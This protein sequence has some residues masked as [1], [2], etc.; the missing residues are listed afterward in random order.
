VNAA[1][2]IDRLRSDFG[3]LIQRNESRRSVEDFRRYRDDPVGFLR[4][5][6]KSDPWEAQC[7]I[8][9]DVRDHPRV[10]VRSCN[11]LGKDW[12]AARLALWGAYA[13]GSMVIVT[14]P[15]SRQVQQIVFGEIR[16]A[17]H[18][19]LELPG[20]LYELELRID[21]TGHTGIM[22]M[23]STDASRLTGYHAPNMLVIMTEAQA[24]EPFGWEAMLACATSEDSR[25]LAVGNPLN[26]SGQFYRVCKS[27]NWKQ[28]RLSAFDHPNLKESREVIP[29]AVTQQWVETIQA[30]YGEGSGVYR[31]RVL[32]DFPEDD[33]NTL[34][35]RSWLEA[36]NE[37]WT[38]GALTLDAVRHPVVLALDPA[39]LGPDS[40]VLAVRRGPVLEELV[41]WS[42]K[43]T[44]QTVGQVQIEM[45]RRRLTFSTETIVDE[46]G[47]GSGV[48]DRLRE[49]RV[50]VTHFNGGARASKPDKFINRRAESFWILRRKLE[51]GTIALPPDEK[52]T[53]E[54]CSMMW[55]TSSTGKIKIE[56]KDLLRERLGRS[57]DRA[58]A[59]AMVFGT[60]QRPMPNL[61]MLGA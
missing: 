5:V 25:V 43:E 19:A 38:A 16:R 36:A 14:G 41:I 2:Q 45:E 51:E 12:L 31:A 47:I 53:D 60:V 29:G 7:K 58:D 13:R 59:V 11:S 44:M 61:R 8:A 3:A 39:R 42:K 32:G 18:S 49:L 50:R 48:A 24:V 21:R 4:D 56:P 34:C 54:L 40:T 10:V 1:Q 17:F 15:T 35:K 46:V 37:R 57:P 6:L 30:E 28:W 52:L 9:L 55:K 26:M 23:T 22:G 33:D 20:E 27:A